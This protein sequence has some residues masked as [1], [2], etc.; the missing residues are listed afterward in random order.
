MHVVDHILQQGD[1]SVDFVESPN[2]GGTLDPKYLVLH[3]TAGRDA[4]GSIRWLAGADARASAHLVIARDGT[5]TQLVPFDRV[6][7]HAGISQWQGLRGLNRH[8][9]GIEL[10]NAG[11][12]E[13]KGERWCAWF[14]DAL[15]GNEV[16]VASHRH[17]SHE[18]GWHVFPPA[19]LEATLEAARALIR[20]YGLRDVLGHDD[21]S[22]GRKADPGPAFPMASFRARL[23]GREEDRPPIFETTVALNIRRGAGTGFE[24]L[25]VSPLPPGARLEV[26]SQD[27]SWRLVNAV[28]EVG[29]DVDVQGWVHGGFI[30]LA[31]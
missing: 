19:Q 7:W 31:E 23:M 12:L 8:S 3:Y 27:G 17:E 18:C 2:R 28:D 22:P 13:E 16:M 25:P 10:D 5:V 29:G 20:A 26:I 1:G 14:G 6:A 9:I 30:R 4:A 21:I 15:P 24:K 11:R